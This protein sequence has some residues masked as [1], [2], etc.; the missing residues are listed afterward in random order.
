MHKRSVV[1]VIVLT[2]ITFGIYAI[3][4]HVKTKDEMVRQGADI[5]TAWLLIVPIA[6]I[7]WYWKWCGGVESVTRGKMSQAVTLLLS[8]LLPGIGMAIIQDAF[9]KASD[10]GLAQQPNLPQARIA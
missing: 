7:Y 10:S 6:S 1:G 2:F 3:V 9:N 5:P 8:L 4:W